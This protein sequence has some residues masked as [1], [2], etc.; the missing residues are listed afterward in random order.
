MKVKELIEK[1]KDFDPEAIIVDYD[2]DDSEYFKAD[3]V[4]YTG[5]SKKYIT[6]WSYSRY[7]DMIEDAFE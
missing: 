6:V 1:L 3:G 4:K 7:A 2:E 5:P